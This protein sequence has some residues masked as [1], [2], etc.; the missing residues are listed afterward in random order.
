MLYGRFAAPVGAR[1]IDDGC[2]VAVTYSASGDSMNCPRCTDTRN[3]GPSSACAAVAP[4]QMIARG[5]TTSISAEPWAARADLHRV[6]LLVDAAFSARLPLE[7]LHDVRDVDL[8]AID[9]RFLEGPVE[10]CAGRSD[11]RMACEIFLVARLLADEHDQRGARAFAE[12]RLRAELPQMTGLAFGGDVAQL[13]Q[14]R[15]GRNQRCGGLNLHA[16]AVEQSACRIQSE[17]C[18]TDASS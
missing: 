12:H 3:F 9:G 13:R 15:T 4:R 6:R 1:R 7:V 2:T 5:W 8:R 16:V 17:A 14:R 18:W 10:Q 11:E